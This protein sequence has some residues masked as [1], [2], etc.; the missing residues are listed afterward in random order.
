MPA[1]CKTPIRRKTVHGDHDDGHIVGRAC[2]R[3]AIAEDLVAPGQ[4]RN[5]MVMVCDELA[6]PHV[7]GIRHRAIELSYNFITL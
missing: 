1:G 6:R 2:D 3:P 5:L 7:T 4:Q